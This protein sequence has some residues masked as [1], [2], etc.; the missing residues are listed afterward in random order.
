LNTEQYAQHLNPSEIT[1]LKLDMLDNNTELR[2]LTEHLLSLRQTGPSTSK[3]FN[4]MKFT[5]AAITIRDDN[6]LMTQNPGIW[7]F[8]GYP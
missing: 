3:N 1:N 2:R 7:N 6:Y 5:E 8:H 4:P